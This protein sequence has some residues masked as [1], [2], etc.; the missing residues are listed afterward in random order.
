[1]TEPGAGDGQGN[2]GDGA[3][4]GD[5]SFLDGITDEGLRANEALKNFENLDGLAKGFVDM[6]GS[7]PTP[8]SDTKDYQVDIPK[9]IEIEDADMAAFKDASLELAL[10]P[11]QYKGVMQHWVSMQSRMMTEYDEE[12]KKIVD[13]LKAEL[14]D[15]FPAA[16]DKA[17]KILSKAPGGQ[18]L[19]EGTPLDKQAGLFKF[20]VWLGG[21]IS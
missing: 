8:P 11:D 2:T 18:D 7:L 19:I 1:M 21:V 3:G 6:K 16:M 10:T 9:G 4:N 15:K 17:N 5:T 12:Q 14:G 20:M 13:G